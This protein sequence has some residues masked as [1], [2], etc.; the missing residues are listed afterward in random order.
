[1]PQGKFARVEKE[2]SPLSQYWRS[3]LEPCVLNLARFKPD[4]CKSPGVFDRTAQIHYSRDTFEKSKKIS[5]ILPMVIPTNSATDLMSKTQTG[6]KIWRTSQNSV[7]NDDIIKLSSP[8]RVQNKNVFTENYGR[9][10]VNMQDEQR[11]YSPPKT[12]F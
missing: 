11:D 9:K 5:T 3:E 1:V 10:V 12:T 6:N 8:K 2:Q 7:F 4:Q